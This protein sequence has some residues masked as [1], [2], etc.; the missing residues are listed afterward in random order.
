MIGEHPEHVARGTG[1]QQF[2]QA[3]RAQRGIFMQLELGRDIQ[4]AQRAGSFRVRVRVDHKLNALWKRRSLGVQ[5]ETCEAPERS[6]TDDR[7]L[8]ASRG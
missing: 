3:A 5:G 8:V 4:V 2:F 1:L 7:L 6:R